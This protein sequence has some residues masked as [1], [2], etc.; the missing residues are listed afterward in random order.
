[1]AELAQMLGRSPKSI[2]TLSLTRS[3]AGNG[4]YNIAAI[5]LATSVIVYPCLAEVYSSNHAIPLARFA[6]ASQ[7]LVPASQ[8]GAQLTFTAQVIDFGTMVKSVQRGTAT[9]A[10]VA[11]SAVNPAKCLCLYSS[12][13]VLG[14]TNGTVSCTINAGSLAFSAIVGPAFPIEWQLIEFR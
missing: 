5:N 1:M 8:G 3:S 7:V 6:S 14:G 13:L 12:H 9:A 10:S 4:T 2:Q 11:I